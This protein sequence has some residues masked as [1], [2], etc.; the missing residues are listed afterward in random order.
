MD[1]FYRN[2]IYP[3]IYRVATYSHDKEIFHV[4]A[5]QI[6]NGI[7]FDMIEARTPEKREDV[8]HLLAVAGFTR[9][10]G[11]DRMLKGLGE[12][13]QMGGTRNI[14]FHMVGSGEPE[15]EYHQI[16]D[17]YN[18]TG[19]CIFHG[20]QRGEALNEIY[21][22]CDMGVE[23]LGDFRNGIFLSSSLKSREYAA[24]GIP[25][26]TAC[27]SDVFEGREYVLKIPADETP[28]DICNVV[29]FYDKLYNEKDTK[30]IV[31]MI[32]RDAEKCCDIVQ[33]MEPVVNCLINK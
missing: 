19:H 13:Y 30:E 7:D 23:S 2:R 31:V 21:D 3:Y 26:I 10:H 22:Y 14:V 28:V 24:K 17:E 11:Y 16:V 29:K 4:P 32:R 1:K 9:A 33:T 27:E 12:Y 6:R 25:F 18:L 15:K 20:V 8:I 5:V